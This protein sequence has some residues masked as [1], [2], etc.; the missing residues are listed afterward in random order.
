MKRIQTEMDIDAPPEAVWDAL[1]DVSAYSEWNPQT[2]WASGEVREGGEVALRVEPSRSRPATLKARVETV[3][4]ERT[5]VWTARLPVPG[6]FAARHAFELEPRP[7]GGTRLRNTETLSGLLVPFVV[8]KDAERDY[9]AMNRALADRSKSVAVGGSD[10]A[11][12][13]AA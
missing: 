9:H 1:T 11:Q 6:L 10:G 3:E 7:D 5:L 12:K 13:R 4:P 2:V 8:R